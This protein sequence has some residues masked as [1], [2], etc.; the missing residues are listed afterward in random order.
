[1]HGGPNKMQGKIGMNISG[2]QGLNIRNYR[3]QLKGKLNFHLF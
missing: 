1:M 2:N 3:T